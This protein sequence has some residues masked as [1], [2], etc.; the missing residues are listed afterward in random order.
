MGISATRSGFGIA[1][2][3]VATLVGSAFA[4][5][6][7]SDQKVYRASA[8][9]NEI[10]PCDSLPAAAVKTM[11]PPFDRYMAFE[12]NALTGQGLRSVDGFHWVNQA[13]MGIGLSSSMQ[14][15]APDAGGDVAF[16][17]SWYTELTAVALSGD[18]QRALHKDFA[19]EIY[20]R[21]LDGA[22]ILELKARTSNGE[23][24]RIFLIVPDTAS[25]PPK[26]LLGLECNGACFT[27]DRQP[28]MFQGEPSGDRPTH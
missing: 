10:V 22:T 16:K 27:E 24:K 11:P 4:E 20:P 23:D 1:V 5:A 6:P 18:E 26:W 21:F 14:V 12:C 19:K 8:G 28:M 7:P 9:R 25:G 15:C 13:G 3:I 2:A 17:Y